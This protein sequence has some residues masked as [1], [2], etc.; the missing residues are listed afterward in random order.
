ME[1]WLRCWPCMQEVP[2]TNPH[3]GRKFFQKCSPKFADKFCKICLSKLCHIQVMNAVWTPNH[4]DFCNIQQQV[5]LAKMDSSFHSHWLLLVFD[6]TDCS[7]TTVANVTHP[8]AVKFTAEIFAVFLNVF[9]YKK[10]RKKKKKLY[11][12]HCE[13]DFTWY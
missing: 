7:Q 5:L 1:Q 4:S 12:P 3:R 2:G 10:R 8:T 13:K 11:L 6:C 9:S